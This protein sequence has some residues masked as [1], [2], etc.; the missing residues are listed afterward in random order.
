MNNL[1]MSTSTNNYYQFTKQMEKL[2]RLIVD[3]WYDYIINYNQ[4]AVKLTET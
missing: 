2:Y 4:T 3:A 1:P